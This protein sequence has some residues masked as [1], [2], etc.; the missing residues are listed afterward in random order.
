VARDLPA[1]AA[2]GGIREPRGQLGHTTAGMSEQFIAG[3]AARRLRRRNDRIAEMIF[4]L[5]KKQK[6][7]A[8]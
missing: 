7:P 4:E 5:R 2:T 3:G 6:G 1:E 8:D